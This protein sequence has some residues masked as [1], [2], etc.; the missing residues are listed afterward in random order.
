MK[1]YKNEKGKWSY[2]FMCNGHRVRKVAGRC[3]TQQE[4]EALACAARERIE[5]EGLGLK[6]RSSTRI[7][8]KAFAEE[9]ISKQV[10]ARPNTIRGYNN[11]LNALLLSKHFKD[12]RLDAVTVESVFSYYAERSREHLVS[13]NREL[14]FLKLVFKRAL[15]WGRVNR[16]PTALVKKHKEPKNKLRILSDD[17]AERLLAAASPAL[18]PFLT[19]LLT[20]AMRPHEVFALRWA[21]DGWDTEDNIKASIVSL[22]KRIIFIPG[23]LAK[24]HKDRE[25]PLSPELIALFKAIPRGASS[26]VFP[27][28]STPKSFKEAIKG[29]K[30]KG[31]DLYTLKHTAASRMIR[32][33]VDLVTVT[34]LIGHAD[35]KTTMIYCHS[36]GDTKREAVEKL[37]RIYAAGQ[38]P[39]DN[40]KKPESP[41]NIAAIDQG[42][43][44]VSNSYE[45]N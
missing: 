34:E 10:R 6:D 16:N 31:V 25:V 40:P 21:Y 28:G 11:C 22:N 26:K 7:L 18:A 13:A 37:S 12:K 5:R 33:G 36:S 43:T 19:V 14:G 39:A 4:C 35:V 15:E 30:L 8:F 42:L 9:F 44:A 2:S 32:A 20:T 27:W 24:N 45:N 38:N 17:E 1:I 29:A 23:G 41:A 3:L